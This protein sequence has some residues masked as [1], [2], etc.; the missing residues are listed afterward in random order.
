MESGQAYI[1]QATLLT[2]AEVT[3]YRHLMRLYGDTVAIF[4]KVRVADVITPDTRRHAKHSRE[5]ASLFRQISQWH[6]D[7]VLVDPGSFKILCAL[8]LDDSS[9]Q[10]PDR[11][12]R[13]RILNSAFL[14][15]GVRL[16]RLTLQGGGLKAEPIT[17]SASP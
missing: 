13:D 9:H 3:A 11:Q 8:E 12:K 7:F 1:S 15:A 14:N 5:F 16:E 6:L 17:N 2:P 4:C 10:R